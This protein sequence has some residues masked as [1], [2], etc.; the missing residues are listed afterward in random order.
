M[1]VVPLGVGHGQVLLVHQQRVLVLARPRYVHRMPPIVV[2]GSRRAVLQT[3]G[4]VSQIEHVMDVPVDKLHRDEVL[5][6]PGVVQDEAVGLQGPELEEQ[7]DVV[8]RLHLRQSHEGVLTA[9][10][11]DVVEEVV[12]LG[13]GGGH[14]VG[15]MLAGDHP[16][17]VGDPVEGQLLD[18]AL[19]RG[20]AG[21]DHVGG[22][23]GAQVQHGVIQE[24]LSAVDLS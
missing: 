8:V 22:E 20:G 13:E 15:R 16:F 2:Q 21:R 9:E 3:D 24:A 11:D 1:C 4:G 12:P 5:L 23:D 6:F 7:V 17:Q 10:G 19:E 18:G 14:L